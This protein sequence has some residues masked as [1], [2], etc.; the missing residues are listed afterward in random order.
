M[1]R[2]RWHASGDVTYEEVGECTV[3]YF[4]PSSTSHS[5]IRDSPVSAE[6]SL[7]FGEEG[8]RKEVLVIDRVV[9]VS[10]ICQYVCTCFKCLLRTGWARCN[11]IARGG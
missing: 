9:P 7:W 6:A 4:E 5:F 2:G 8:R 1:A 10:A 3:V 11:R